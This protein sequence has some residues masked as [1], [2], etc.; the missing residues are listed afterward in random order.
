MF[1]AHFMGTLATHILMSLSSDYV[2]TDRTVINSSTHV[3]T[4]YVW[5]QIGT[6]SIPGR[7]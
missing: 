3:S 5:C 6:E 4:F 1:Y 7:I 2:L